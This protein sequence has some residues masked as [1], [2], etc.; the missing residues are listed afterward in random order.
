MLISLFPNCIF[1]EIN[2]INIAGTLNTNSYHGV[3]TP[4]FIIRD[5]S[6]DKTTGFTV[7]NLRSVFRCLKSYMSAGYNVINISDITNNLRK[8]YN[9]NFGK[10]RIKKA[11]SV[12]D[13]INLIKSSVQYNTLTL[14]PGDCYTG[15]CDIESSPTYVKTS[16]R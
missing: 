15:S 5:I 16:S 8:M 14:M 3:V 11:L 12:F 10:E 7:E 9:C 13:E 6:P 2:I 1:I 4:Q